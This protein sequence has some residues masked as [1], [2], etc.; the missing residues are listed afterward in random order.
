MA[1]IKMVGMETYIQ[2]IR[3]IEDPAK[4][5]RAAVKAG[6]GVI[7]DGIRQ[8]LQ[9]E[10]LA[11]SDKTALAAYQHKFPMYCSESQKK[12]LLKGLG[13]TK[14][15][16][17]RGIYEA[18]VGFDGYN[19][20]K[21]KLWPEGQPNALIAQSV[22]SGRTWMIKQPFVRP[23]VKRLENTALVAMKQAADKKLEEI[24]GGNSNGT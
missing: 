16:V 10:V 14:I 8:E 15:H 1:K 2:Q 24:L 18:K 5:C 4:V 6:A 21:T 17:K 19:D 23:T 22:E 12:G 9:S 20:V 3:T 11:V 7:A 13:I